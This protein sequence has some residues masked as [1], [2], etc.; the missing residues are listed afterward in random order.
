MNGRVIDTD[1]IELQSEPNHS[2]GSRSPRSRKH[3]GYLIAIVL[4]VLFAIIAIVGLMTR[5]SERKALAHETETLAVATVSVVHPKAE[6]PQEELVLPSTLQAFTESPIYARTNGYLKGWYKDIGSPVRQGELLADIETP[7]IDQELLQARAA[8]DQSTAQLQIAQTSAKRWETL[9]KMDAVAQQE[10][11]ERSSSFAQAKANLA[12]AE[13]NVHRLEQLESFKHIYAPFSGVLT[14]RNIDIG[15]LINAGNNGPNQQLF[16][17][18]RID[19]IR[20]YVN[21]PEIYAPSV[22]P[23]VKSTIELS[24]I[25]GKEFSGNVVRT[26]ESID[27]ATRT[28]LTEIDVPNHKGELLPGAYAQV[29]FALN[30]QIPRLSVPVNALLFRA[31]GVRAA[32]VDANGQVQLKP[33]AIGRDYGRDVEVLSGVEASD[34]LVLNPA[35]SLESG[36]K[37]SVKQAGAK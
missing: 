2:S 22:R 10:T 30:V 16:N 29:H 27:P 1:D 11:D 12:A 6:P 14:R 8:R 31:E 5:F 18:A 19:P 20:V 28:L 25:S 26:A 36:E 3:R 33:V 4:G 37:V 17:I 13:A 15:A 7:E 34:L 24:S 35:D 32:V 23:G 21:V 9:Q